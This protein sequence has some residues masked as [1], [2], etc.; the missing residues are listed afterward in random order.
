MKHG[1]IVWV[2]F[3]GIYFTNSSKAASLYHTINELWY[4]RSCND[5]FVTDLHI[6]KTFD[7]KAKRNLPVV[8]LF[9]S[10]ND[11]THRHNLSSIEMLTY[12]GQMPEAL[13]VGIG[14]REDNR[15]L[16]TS[17]QKL[18]NNPQSGLEAM[19]QMLFS[20]LLPQLRQKYLASGP[21]LVLGHSRTAYLVNYLYTNHG[22]KLAVAGCFSGFFEPGCTRADFQ[23][24]VRKFSQQRRGPAYYA[25]W[26]TDPWQEAP[27]ATALQGIDSMVLGLPGAARVRVQSHAGAGH[28]MNHNLSVPAALCWFFAPY[29]ELF[30]KWL[31]DEVKK[32]PVDSLLPQLNRAYAA[33]ES[34]LGGQI[35]LPLDVYISFGNV[36]WQQEQWGAMEAL[37]QQGK[38]T[39]PTD[40]EL[41]YLLA[42]SFKKQGK[43]TAYESLAANEGKR[44]Q[45]DAQLKES[46]KNDILSAYQELATEP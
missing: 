17:H 6:P 36:L 18:P 39:F 27:Y 12:H 5:S 24:A 22:H 11:N 41:H 45:N 13:V 4:S 44:A 42:L 29:A 43:T 31:Y 46:E 14:F 23:S 15:Y 3:S 9:D 38:S 20:E 40:Y 1:F 30:N 35:D 37:L 21:V 34:Q 19:A 32:V 33:L 7:R 10:Q 25:S 16:L 8:I 28:L 26:G 2:I